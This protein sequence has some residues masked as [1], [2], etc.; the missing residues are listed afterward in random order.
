V[1]KYT[2]AVI[3]CGGRG[4][5][6]A[7]AY[8]LIDRAEVVACADLDPARAEAL[9]KRFGIKPYTDAAEMLDAEKPDLIHITT[10][11]TARANVMTL[12]SGAGVPACTVEKPIA[13][14]ASDWRE[15][16]GLEAASKTRFAVCH[17]FRYHEDL[18][19]CREAL[20]SGA[21]GDVRFIE[22]SAGMNICGQGTHVLDYGMSLNGDSPVA[23]VFGAASGTD[24]L[25]GYHPAPDSTTG[26][27]VFENGARASWTNGPLA[28]RFGDPETDWQH[29]RAAAYADRGRVEWRE[30]GEW[31]IVGPGATERGDFGGMDAW[32]AGNARTQAAFHNSMLDWIEDASA[33]PGTNL[34]QSLHEWKVVLALYESSVTRAPVDLATFDP[35]DGIMRR[36]AEALGK[37]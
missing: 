10:P 21:L 23:R 8:R 26:Y 1:A 5:A 34:A 28:P 7:D 30:F 6:H 14:D 11:P 32:R 9:A 2:A 17:Q 36:L 24:G 27:L 13:T 35:Q 33:V 16:C 20:G 3:G 31:V 4:R 37:R 15:L 19:R 18:T 25:E 12:V 22:I 29:V